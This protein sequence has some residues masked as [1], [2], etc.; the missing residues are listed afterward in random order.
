MRWRATNFAL[1]H[2]DSVILASDIWTNVVR[3]RRGGIHLVVIHR[4]R[5][6]KYSLA[7]PQVVNTTRGHNS[8]G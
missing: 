6:M 4:E 1:G 8:N 5:K 2:Q 7:G 3:V